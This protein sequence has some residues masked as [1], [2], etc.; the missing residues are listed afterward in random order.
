MLMCPLQE[1]Y[2]DS[3]LQWAVN[4]RS[5]EEKQIYYTVYKKICTYLSY[6]SM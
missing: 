4:K 2:L 3:N 6:F 1:G 5:N